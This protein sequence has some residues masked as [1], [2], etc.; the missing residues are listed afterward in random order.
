MQLVFMM[1]T[2]CVFCEV[3]Y[4]AKET[5]NLTISIEAGCVLCVVQANQRSLKSKQN[6]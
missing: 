5:V 6:K 2:G 4:E 1:E 3:K